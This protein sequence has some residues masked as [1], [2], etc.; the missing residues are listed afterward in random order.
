[1]GGGETFSA[2]KKTIGSIHNRQTNYSPEHTFFNKPDH[3]F[4]KA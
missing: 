4:P 3:M 1:M 2:G